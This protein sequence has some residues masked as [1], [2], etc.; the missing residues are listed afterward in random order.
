[1]NKKRSLAEL[2]AELV[3][4]RDTH[5]LKKIQ[6]PKDLA[7]ALVVEA[8]DILAHFQWKQPDQV[9]EYLKRHKA[10]LGE[11][12]VVVFNYVLLMAHDFN[13]DIEKILNEKI[14]KNSMKYPRKQEKITR[15]TI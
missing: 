12:L 11:E 6:N 10:S 15:I 9:S 3:A 4:L 5:G 2:T 7:L 14:R 8:T 13:L 1:M